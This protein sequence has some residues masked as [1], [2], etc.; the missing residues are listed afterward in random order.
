MKTE[1]NAHVVV[2]DWDVVKPDDDYLSDK[3]LTNSTDDKSYGNKLRK[4]AKNKELFDA[5]VVGAQNYLVCIQMDAHHI[6]ID[7]DF[8]ELVSCESDVIGNKHKQVARYEDY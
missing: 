6:I 2:T 8:N 4:Q 7:E 5:W 1:T 3:W